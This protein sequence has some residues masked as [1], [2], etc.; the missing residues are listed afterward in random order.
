MSDPFKKF[1]EEMARLLARKFNSSGADSSP[2]TLI[3]HANVRGP[4]YYN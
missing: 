1:V 3:D 2:V 4:R